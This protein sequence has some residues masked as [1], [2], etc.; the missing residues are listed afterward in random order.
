MV[1]IAIVAIVAIGVVCLIIGF[2]MDMWGREIR[3]WWPTDVEWL[4]FGFFVTAIGGVL[5][6]GYTIW[7]M[8]W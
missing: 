2:V 4:L 6:A 8:L 1:A 7:D 5:L 3:E